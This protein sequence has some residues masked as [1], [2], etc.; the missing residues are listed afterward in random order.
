MCRYWLAEGQILFANINI[1]LNTLGGCSALHTLGGWF[2]T[3]TRTQDGLDLHATGALVVILPL[4]VQMVYTYLHVSHTGSRIQLYRET[5][6]IT[7]ITH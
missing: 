5:R 7:L 1:S 6:A 4:T 2:S 3:L